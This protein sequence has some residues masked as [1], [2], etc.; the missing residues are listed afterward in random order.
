[1]DGHVLQTWEW[2]GYIGCQAR[3]GLP[4]SCQLEMG[5]GWEALQPIP[6]G[7]PSSFRTSEPP[8]TRLPA[9]CR[10]GA[11]VTT[12]PVPPR[13]TSA[14]RDAGL[15]KRR[16]RSGCFPRA[17]QGSGL[18]TVG[19]LLGG[20]GGRRLAPPVDREQPLGLEAERA[21]RAWTSAAVEHQGQWPAALVCPRALRSN[22][23]YGQPTW[24]AVAEGHEDGCPYVPLPAHVPSVGRQ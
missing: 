20:S 23:S 24:P 18:R 10:S 2:Q 7:R 11:H 3:K 22:G 4:S 12:A 16:P 15:P 19:V 14:R 9:R 1:M 21:G 5:A 6:S 17:P 13:R 8:C